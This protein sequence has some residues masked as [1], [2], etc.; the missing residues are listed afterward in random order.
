MGN[1]LTTIGLEI[2]VEM[3]TNSKLLSPSPVNFGDSPNAN[4][5]VI[6]WGY[7][8]VLP[9]VNKGAIEFGMKAALALNAEITRDIRWDRKNYIYP[10]N[11]KSYQTTQQATPLG[12]HGY[13]E[14]EMEDG[15]TKRVGI[16]ELHVEEDAGKN[17]HGGDGYSYVDLNRQGTPLLEIVTEPDIES[18]EVA[19]AFLEKLRQIIQFTGISDVKMQEGSLRVDA[20]ISLRPAGS[21]E[22]GTRVEMKN[23]NSFS[24]LRTA[25][26][27]EQK[28]Q[29]QEIIAGNQ[30]QQQTR[31][32]DEPTK[33]TILMRTKEQADDYRYFPEPDL[34]PMHI[35]QTWVDEVA[36]TLPESADSRLKRYVG[37][38][39]LG[40]KEAGVLVQTLEMANFYDAT[41]AAGADAKKAANYLIGDVNSYLNDTQKDLQDTLLTPENLAGMINLI[42][43]GT[44]S[45]KQAKKVFEAITEGKEPKAYVEENG[46]VQESRVEVLQPVIA[47]IV[48]ANEQSVADFKAG[49]DRAVGFLVGQIMKQT[50]GNANPNVVN[51]IL[52]DELNSR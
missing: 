41:V 22:F 35:D 16:R 28:R 3:K 10:D 25:L 4:T 49:K 8:G 29:S 42:E 38:F 50:H 43:D 14:F 9:R 12:Q 1:F 5:N 44:I 19:S 46:L 23:L 36:A 13:V 30:I 48:D 32:Y 2:H 24:Y 47:S 20:N 45:S 7:P 11:P 21:D 15:T 51:Q 26:A 33:S 39:E 27:Y 18:P 34:P 6:D 31:R 37:E 52:L 17:T 40:A